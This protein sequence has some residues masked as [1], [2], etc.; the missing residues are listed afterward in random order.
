MSRLSDFDLDL[1]IGQE[2]EQ[3][4][5]ELLTGGLTVEV[6]RDLRWKDT[7]NVYIETQGWSKPKSEWYPSGLSVTKAAY[8]AL[9]LEDGALLVPT[10][11]LKQTVIR[12]GREVECK[13]EPNFSRGYLV[14]PQN[15]ID[16]LRSLPNEQRRKS[17]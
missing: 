11:A 12:H 8:W 13:L 2:G 3:L 17:Q 6:K 15:I 4:V 7:G 9:V 10:G 5:R 1:A 14:K 16:T